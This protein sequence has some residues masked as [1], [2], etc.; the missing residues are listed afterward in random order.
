[1]TVGWTRATLETHV[2]VLAARH[3]GKSF[4]EA[5]AVLAADLDDDEITMLREILL[6]RAR[7]EGV[8]SQALEERIDA[9]REARRRLFR[10]RP[11]K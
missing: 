8:Y 6:R 7:E 2:T 3:E 1:V 11:Q 9:P 4:V 10:R 5:I